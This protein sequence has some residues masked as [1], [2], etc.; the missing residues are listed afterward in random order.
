MKLIIRY[1]IIMSLLYNFL[2]A[3]KNNY[4]NLN[5]DN[6]IILLAAT[7]EDELWSLN[8][9]KLR[10]NINDYLIS[11]DIDAVKIF[12]SDINKYVLNAY[13]KDDKIIF[14][15]EKDLPKKFY[16]KQYK[17]K[18][19]TIFHENKAIGKVQIYYKKNIFNE[20]NLSEEELKWLEEHP[21]IKVHAESSWEPFNFTENGE[22]LGYSNDY[23]RLLASKLGINIEFVKGY[24]WKEYIQMLK[25]KKIDIISNL[26]KTPKR[27]DFALFT[28]KSIHS[29][30]PAIYSNKINTTF[31][32]IEEL[33][34][35]KVAFV[36]GHWLEEI[37]K[38]DYPQI[39]TTIT[40]NTYE[41]IKLVSNGSVDAII[42]MAPV[43]QNII[44]KYAVNNIYFHGISN[45]KK[46]EKYYERIGIRKD[47]K[48]FKNILDKTIDSLSY[49]EKQTLNQTWLISRILDSKEIY[50]N[51]KKSFTSQLLLNSG[52]QPVVYKDTKKVLLIHSYHPGYKWT[53]DLTQGVLSL[54]T[55]KSNVDVSIEYMD[56]KRKFDKKYIEL[57]KTSYLYR[58]GKEKFDLIIVSDN[59][60]FN[61]I[62]ENKKD[63]FPNTAI[64]FAGVNNFKDEMLFNKKN[65]TGIIEKPDLRGTIELIL[66]IK[67]NLKNLLV[68][69]DQTVTGKLI[70]KRI[71]NLE[72]EYEEIKFINTSD[73]TKEELLKSVETLNK[74]SAILFITFFKDKNNNYFNTT[75]VTKAISEKTD[76]PI[77]GL[78][79]F[80]I[81]EGII[82]GKLISGYMQGLE[83]ANIGNKILQGKDAN[84]IS[85]LKKTKAN[86]IFD[87][88]ALDKSNIKK[89]ELPNN[90][91]IIGENN[92]R[93]ESKIDLSKKEELFLK[94]NPKIIVSNEMQW[95]PFDFVVGNQPQGYFIDLLKLLSEKIGIDIE[96]I[97]GYTWAELMKIFENKNIDLIHPVS[98]NIE[99]NKKWI[100]SK[101]AFS[102]ELAYAIKQNVPKINSISSLYGKTIAIS[103]SFAYKNF[104]TTN[105]PYIKFKIVNSTKEGLELVSKGLAYAI[106]DAKPALK[107]IAK[108][109][110]YSTI[111]ITNWFSEYKNKEQ[112]KLHFMTHKE[113]PELI[114]MINKALALLTPGELTSLEKK[115]FGTNNQKNEE[116]KLSFN[117]KELRY[118][119]NKKKIK[120]CVLPNA[121][122]YEAIDENGKHVGIAE[123]LIRIMEKKIG[124]PIQLVAT[125]TWAQSHDYIKKG[126]CDIL[127]VAHNLP[128]RREYL[129]FTKPYVTQTTVIA[130]R[131]KELFVSSIDQILDKKIAIVEK[132][133]H[134]ALVKKAY[135]NLKIIAVKNIKEGLE[136]V[137]KKEVYGY[138]D[139]LGPINYE[140]QRE[141]NY[142]IKIAG[143]IGFDLK[144]AVATRKDEPILNDI[145]TQA[146]D[147]FTQED[148]KKIYDKWIAVKVEEKIDYMLIYKII[149]VSFV[150]LLSM[151]LWGTKLRAEIKKRKE[152]EKELIKAQEDALKASQT[153]SE[154][155][156]N[157]SHEIRTPMN[158]IIGMTS[159]AI[160]NLD[161]DIQESKDYIK[162]AQTS[163]N[164]LL[165]IINDI[166]DFSKIEVGKLE[167]NNEAIN[168]RE[169]VSDINDIFNH[170]IEEKNLEFIIEQDEFIPEYILGDKLRLF[171]ILTNLISNS[172]KFTEKGYV[173]VKI[174]FLSKEEDKIKI[175]FSVI[176]TGKGIAK[177]N[178]EKLFKSFSQEDSSISKEYGG[179]GL[180]LAIS[181]KLVELM[182]GDISFKSKKDEGSNFYFTIQTKIVQN[183]K[184]KNNKINENEIQNDT[185]IDTNILL[186]EDNKINQE[187]AVNFLKEYVRNIDFVQNGKEAI[188]ILKEK[189]KDYYKLILMDIHM[190][191]MDGYTA[192]KKIKENEEIKHIP[193]IA[194]TANALSSDIKKCLEYGMIDHIAKPL[195]ILLLEKKIRA[196]L[197]DEKSI[198]KFQKIKE[199]KD[200]S[201]LPSQKVFNPKVAIER[202][203]GRKDLYINLLINFI[204]SEK[205]Y[206]SNIKNYVNN[207]DFQN[208][209]SELHTLKG[210]TRTIGAD[211]F[212]DFLESLE[213]DTKVGKLPNKETLEKIHKDFDVIIKDCNTWLRTNEEQV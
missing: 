9:E 207:Q 177:K 75:E 25:D 3:Q 10:S 121:L 151:I 157:M 144:L 66:K 200:L 169:I 113:K 188:E 189:D 145:F 63:I 123:D 96:F 95:P 106:I 31:K 46:T 212:G 173:K 132:Y 5:T 211:D 14:L 174:E 205:K 49:Q 8:Y 16:S 19:R 97:N 128:K 175:K 168:L 197:K 139:S 194:M 163:A 161:K 117:I 131:N 41:A 45:F 61:F 179:T 159:L 59:N 213:K 107:Y 115:W 146:I 109:N 125:K 193:I 13:K 64:V 138:I 101:A 93:K 68:V 33:K 160:K 150:I 92:Y 88:N 30:P 70:N 57:L 4:S 204:E 38:N 187:L 50:T 52:Y 47:W 124:I 94:N 165:R 17:T 195:D 202:M 206:I 208:L 100:F 35:Y 199:E 166:L 22:A 55:K 12:D 87:K 185:I 80:L 2:L 111:K 23:I 164:M 34:G 18:N 72:K 112:K 36:K 176:D 24:A 67:K 37:L 183:K 83:A 114:S 203:L 143:K 90:S 53:D 152:I 129:N 172:I 77:F 29:I 192:T 119:Q 178:Q 85:V 103:K 71:K 122:P 140:I 86:F 98:K 147:A 186:V 69:T 99:K 170:M 84:S 54:F 182:N 104:Y 133:A 137:R 32:S 51:E 82:G 181:K 127:P 209:S 120:M 62:L 21:S 76:L 89:E 153:K 78:W 136:K 201:L 1:F 167:I 42:G 110:F 134:A 56:T 102:Y 142:E 116:E 135:P 28:Q 105:Y 184:I 149:A 171:Q 7:I 74:Q 58:Y 65:I 40:K 190:P 6:N 196:V 191:I 130:T 198:K 141:G 155:L 158:G 162:K 44:T 126:L 27:E 79:D 43:I 73:F 118:L 81:G 20:I 154:F 148:I 180:G 11:T 39:Q 15:E 156:A 91:I 108:K 48:I 60:A 210:L 26:V